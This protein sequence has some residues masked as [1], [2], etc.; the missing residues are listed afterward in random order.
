MPLGV[1]GSSFLYGLPLRLIL[2]TPEKPP[3][4][5]PYFYR[6]GPVFTYLGHSG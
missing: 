4:R 6:N 2:Y 3:S 5:S 1:P